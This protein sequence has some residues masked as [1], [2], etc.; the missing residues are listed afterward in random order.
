MKIK[1]EDSKSFII[2]LK[3]DRQIIFTCDTKTLCSEWIIVLNYALE[4]N[5]VSC[6]FLR[7][8]VKVSYQTL[9]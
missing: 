9:I 2:G 3:D 6:S 1:L 4:R 8:N 5:E 7:F